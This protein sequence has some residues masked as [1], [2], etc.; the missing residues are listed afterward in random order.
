[1]SPRDGSLVRPLLGFTREQTAAYC[2]S[3]G[4]TWREDESNDDPAFARARV[5]HELIP[6]L[7]A[8]H[9]AAERNVLAVAGRLREE[10]AVLDG[11]VDEVLQGAAAIEL[12]RLADVPPALAALVVQR[13]ADAAA[14]A[15]APGVG[16]RVG[17]ILAL[18]ADG[19]LHLGSGLRAVVR[20]GRL[21]FEP[22]G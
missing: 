17:E 2:T 9:P 14:G 22:L 18:R 10:A 19:E 6:A 15:P 5:R 3:A 16:A 20:R 12:D 8:I 7:R 11:L 1:M 13:L 4:L 21:A